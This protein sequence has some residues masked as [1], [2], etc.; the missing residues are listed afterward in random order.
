MSYIFRINGYPA[1]TKY[2]KI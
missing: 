1:D 2:M